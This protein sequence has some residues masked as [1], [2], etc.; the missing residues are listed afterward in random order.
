M[1]SLGY[2]PTQR[3]LLAQKQPRDDAMKTEATEACFFTDRNCP[4]IHTITTEEIKPKRTPGA[5][6]T[7][8]GHASPYTKAVGT[9][10]NGKLSITLHV[11]VFF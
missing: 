2:S 6:L 9:F 8:R 1:Q 5:T 7:K 11:Y 3:A 10:L 4:D